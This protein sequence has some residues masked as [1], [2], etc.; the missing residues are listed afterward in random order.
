[1]GVF[2]TVEG[3]EGCGKSTVLSIVIERLK[4]EGYDAL[5]T[6]EPGGIDISEQIRSVIL[7]VNN[8]KMDKVTEA[9]L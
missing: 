5:V 6:R 9:L 2:I 7:D 1:M 3:G 8:T 4:Q